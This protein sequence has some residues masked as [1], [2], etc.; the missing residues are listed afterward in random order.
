MCYFVRNNQVL[1]KRRSMKVCFIARAAMMVGI[2]WIGYG[3]IRGFD[4]RLDVMGTA[5]VKQIQLVG[6]VS[7]IT[8]LAIVIGIL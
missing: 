1:A 6:L 7:E 2:F 3:D 8:H 5:A 4:G